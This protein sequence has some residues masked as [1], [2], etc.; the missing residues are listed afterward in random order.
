MFT[1][2]R[3]GE[4]LPN[5]VDVLSREIESFELCDESIVFWNTSPNPYQGMSSFC[6][7]AICSIIFLLSLVKAG[8]PIGALVLDLGAA[9]ACGCLPNP[10]RV[11][12]LKL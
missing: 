9:H 5:G 4:R 6:Y 2:S 10:V 1:A 11:V 12:E 8:V 3:S 7:F